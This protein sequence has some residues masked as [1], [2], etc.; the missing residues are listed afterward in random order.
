VPEALVEEE[1]RVAFRQIAGASALGLQDVASG[2]I[3]K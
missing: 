3:S 1:K 2:L